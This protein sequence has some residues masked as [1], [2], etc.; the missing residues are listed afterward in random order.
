MNT[1]DEKHNERILYFLNQ[2]KRLY[3]DYVYQ[4]CVLALTHKFEGL[5]SFDTPKLEKQ[6]GII[7]ESFSNKLNQTI[8][9][10]IASQ[11]NY[12][13]KKHDALLY[14][15]KKEFGK[16]L[17]KVTHNANALKAFQDRK[18]NGFTISERVWNLTNQRQKEIEFAIDL[19]LKEGQSAMQL[20]RSV[21]QHLNQPDKLFRR[22]RD[23]HGNLVLSKNAKAFHPGQ[24]VYR[25]SYKNALRLASNEINIAYRESEQLRIMQN[26]DVVGVEIHLSPQHSAYDMCDELKGKYPKDF[27]WNQWHVNCK[28][29]RRMILKK[30]DEFFKEI[31]NNENLSPEFSKNY[32]GDIPNNAKKWFKDNK[33]RISRLKAKPEWMKENREFLGENKGG[34][35]TLKSLM[36][37]A[38]N[39]SGQVSEMLKKLNN[40]YGGYATPVNFKSKDSIIRKVTTELDG[41]VSQVKDA[42]RATV[43]LP[44]KDYAI[45]AK[46]LEK[47]SNFERVKFQSPDKFSGYSGI[48]T[49]FKTSHGIYAEIQFNTE[50]MIYAKE[51]P[52]DAIRIIGKEKWQKIKNEVGLE[53][54]LGHQYY[55]KIRVLDE[56][57]PKQAY[58]KLKLEKLSAEYYSKFR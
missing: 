30:E 27:K 36:Q 48:I 44:I 31:E 20:N 18:I 24:G 52:A 35:V 58:E 33:E 25:S 45:L 17:P 2:I 39:S 4:Y 55:E 57:I 8:M 9:N 13:N 54:G 29:H 56:K 3:G 53:G 43:I 34:K 21:K 6:T 51:K 42:I 38:I 5:F 41:D 37:K 46:D 10:G 15:V 19:A 1:F 22:I 23:K 47:S 50:K 11:W 16:S 14:Q 40:K 26:N 49:N 28:C 12:A 7:K 32:V